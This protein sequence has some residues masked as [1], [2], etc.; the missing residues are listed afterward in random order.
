MGDWALVEEVE[1]LLPCM[2]AV[3]LRFSQISLFHRR[4]WMDGLLWFVEILN[5]RKVKWI[6]IIKASVHYVYI[7]NIIEERRESYL[8]FFL[9]LSKGSKTTL[10]SFF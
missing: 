6:A 4:R 7:N 9:P 2:A 10:E 3:V 8:M 5:S 1:D